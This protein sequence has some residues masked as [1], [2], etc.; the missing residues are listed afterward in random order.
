L[1]KNGA[2]WL[3]RLFVFSAV[4]FSWIFFR[5][6]NLADVGSIIKSFR[7]GNWKSFYIGSQ[8]HFVLGVLGILLVLFMEKMQGE[9][10]FSDFIKNK[11]LFFRWGFYLSATIL[12]LMIG[13]F[14]GG[15]FLYADF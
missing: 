5:A 10:V 12:I 13:V 9:M 15:Q 8:T 6:G 2:T 3:N 1:T 14:D 7:T 4:S 11:N